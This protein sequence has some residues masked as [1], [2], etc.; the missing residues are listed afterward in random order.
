MNNCELRIGE[1]IAQ[2]VVL[3]IRIMQAAHCALVVAL[4]YAPD[5]PEFVVAREYLKR[6]IALSGEYHQ[7]FWSI[8]WKTSP[9]RVKRR[10]RSQCHQ[11]AFDTYKAHG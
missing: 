6:A 8:F 5:D 9:E 4:Q 10:I 7:L 2:I 3:K 1:A 11:L